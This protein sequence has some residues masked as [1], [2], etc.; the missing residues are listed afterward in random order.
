MSLRA[1]VGSLFGCVVAVGFAPAS[2]EADGPKHPH[3]HHALYELGEA[4]TELKDAAHDFGGHRE[5]ALKAVDTAMTQ[6]AKA[7]EAVG[8]KYTAKAPD[9]DVYKKYEHHP[10]IQHALHELG[11]AR[12]E[13]KDAKHD[14]G[15]HREKTL[16]DV[17]HA[18]TQL[19]A[20]LKFAKK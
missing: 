4:R 16:K 6:M 12:K 1:I 13:L 3:M 11:E 18:I 10:H 9:K 7:L 15:G 5:K 8:D 2:A 19:E 17:D 20:A 14:F